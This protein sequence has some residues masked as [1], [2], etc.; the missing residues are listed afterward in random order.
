M[1]YRV[2][3]WATRRGSPITQPRKSLFPV[4]DQ[5]LCTHCTHV[6]GKF[7]DAMWIIKFGVECPGTDG[8][9]AETDTGVRKDVVKRGREDPIKV[10]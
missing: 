5:A 3:A 9:I 4:D 7:W 10:L 2:S 1:T 8:L 6:A